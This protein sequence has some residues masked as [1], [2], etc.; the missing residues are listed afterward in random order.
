MIPQLSQDM[1]AIVE[2]AIRVID[3]M[4]M[5]AQNPSMIV[6]SELTDFSKSLEDFELPLRVTPGDTEEI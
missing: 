2:S 4:L 5:F 3:A 1:P 6:A